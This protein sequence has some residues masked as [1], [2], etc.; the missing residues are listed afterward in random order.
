M[1]SRTQR[2]S[3][4]Q[5]NPAS[6]QHVDDESDTSFDSV[7]GTPA[8]KRAHNAAHEAL[9]MMIENDKEQRRA[10]ERY[11]AESLRIQQDMVGL[12]SSLVNA[13][14]TDIRDL[15]SRFDSME[16]NINRMVS[17]LTAQTTQQR[18]QTFSLVQAISKHDV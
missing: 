7:A 4:S 8:R 12:G 10:D 5:E 14:T 17:L 16:S 3:S 11:R 1:S 6:S 18:S 13:M 15:K 2:A 9:A